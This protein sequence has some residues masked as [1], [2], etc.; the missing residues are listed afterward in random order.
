MHE[1]V[2]VAIAIPQQHAG[3]LLLSPADGFRLQV[4]AGFAVELVCDCD[5]GRLIEGHQ[6]G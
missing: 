4:G 5:V 1:A 2:S 3:F 6:A